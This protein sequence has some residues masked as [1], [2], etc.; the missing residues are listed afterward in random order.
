MLKVREYECLVSATDKFLV[1]DIL[2]IAL[3]LFGEV[4]GAFAAAK[5]HMREGD[6]F[7][8]YRQEV[9]E[10]F[11]DILW[12]F[13]ALCRRFDTSVEEIIGSR[14]LETSESISVTTGTYNLGQLLLAA[15]EPGERSV[16][17]LL[18]ELGQ[19]AAAL[20][21]VDAARE[22]MNER[23]VT[24][25]NAYIRS[26]NGLKIDFSTVAQKNISKVRGRFLRAPE[27]ELPEFDSE[28]PE[29]ERIPER[30][31][32]EISEKANG[33][34]YLKWNG[35]FIGDPLSDNISDNDGYRY[36]DVFHFAHAAVLHWSPT[37]RALIKHKRKSDSK[38]EE[39]QDSGRAIVIEEGLTAYIFS[40]AKGLAFFEGK[41]GVSFGLL[42][43]VSE[44]VEGYEV[45]ACPLKLWEDAIIQ[46]YQVFRQVVQ[47]RGGVIVGDR[48]V[49]KI[50]V[51]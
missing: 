27:V 9:E 21:E 24:F 31:E 32:I 13:A 35:V 45:E 3:G 50:Y 41:A 34:T 51:K 36:H 29:D 16:E 47:N 42:K 28:F 43:T 2:P 39:E 12:Y 20:L 11:G 33:R 26:L 22:T 5:K 10:E 17:P 30:F 38:V 14:K 8:K 37:F 48:S 7:I 44:F 40:Q 19:A 1:N 4:G 49:R 25:A 15:N 6:A 46:G 18:R 23:L